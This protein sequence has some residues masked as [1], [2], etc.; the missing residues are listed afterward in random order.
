MAYDKYWDSISVERTLLADS[1]I[2]G[3]IEGKIEGIEL[4]IV[5]GYKTGGTIEFLSNMAQISPEKIRE[6]LKNH[7]LVTDEK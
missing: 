1:F 7:D 4:M 5:N 2:E 3:K 6:I